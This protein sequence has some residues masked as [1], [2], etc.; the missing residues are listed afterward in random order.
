MIDILSF[1]Y[2]QQASA[3]QAVCVCVGEGVFKNICIPHASLVGVTQSPTYQSSIENLVPGGT[4]SV[5]SW[6][7]KL[8]YLFKFFEGLNL[9]FVCICNEKD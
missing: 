5:L 8:N 7:L 1:F 4:N 3:Q 9:V 6:V 2:S